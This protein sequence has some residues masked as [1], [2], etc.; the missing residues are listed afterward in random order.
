MVIWWIQSSTVLLHDEPNMPISK[1]SFWEIYRKTPKHNYFYIHNTVNGIFVY[2]IDE[3]GDKYLI[4][5][6]N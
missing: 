6:E 5:E 2:L 3:N 1:E 4:N